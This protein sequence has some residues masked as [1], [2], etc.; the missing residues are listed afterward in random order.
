MKEMIR[1]A[2]VTLGFSNVGYTKDITTIKGRLFEVPA[3][4][5]L[6]LTQNAPGLNEY[7]EPG[8]EVMI[9][10]NMQECYEQLI[11]LSN[12]PEKANVIRNAGHNKML[13]NGNWSA[14]IAYLEKLISGLI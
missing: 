13:Y 4:G 6:L 1:K 12:N 10:N 14:R 2:P 8:K 11:F 7:F 3:Y 9:F 5:G